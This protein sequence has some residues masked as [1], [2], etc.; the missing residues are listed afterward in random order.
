MWGLFVFVPFM[1]RAYRAVAQRHISAHSAVVGALFRG[2]PI[3]I[4]MLTAG[5]VL[6]IMII[7]F[8]AS[9][10]REVFTAVPAPQGIGLRARLDDVGISAWDIV[11]PYTR[12]A[13]IG[14]SSSA[15]AARSARRWR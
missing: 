2:P 15:S 14:A 4:G 13:V 5:I 11:L 10:M 9:V 7:P 6:A 3:G 12:S 1:A 8:I